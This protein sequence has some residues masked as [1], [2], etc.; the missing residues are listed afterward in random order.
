MMLPRE[1]A[2]VRA[3]HPD[4]EVARDT[5]WLQGLH[6]DDGPYVQMLVTPDDGLERSIGDGSAA[7]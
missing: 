5:A 3:R 1:D 7:A 2:P 4:I 6:Y